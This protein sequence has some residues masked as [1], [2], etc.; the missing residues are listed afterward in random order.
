MIIDYLWNL[1]IH[2][3]SEAKDIIVKH[4][5]RVRDY[6]LEFQERLHKRGQE[7]DFS[8]LSKEEL[9]YFEKYT[10]FQKTCKYGSDEYKKFLEELSPALDHH[11]KNNR[12]HPEHYIF[13]ECAGCF[14]K[15]YQTPAVCSQCGYSIFQKRTDISQMSLVD[16]VEMFCDW[17]AAGEQHEDGG[18]IIR[19]IEI[20]QERFGYTDELKR[21]LIN[22]ANYIKKDPATRERELINSKS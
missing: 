19:S 9:P 2:K 13:Y 21:I 20:N 18:D 14:E 11:Y 5:S 10:P 6:L 3:M 22:T 17:I 8:K 7:H 12:H 15:Y 16:L 4:I 1:E